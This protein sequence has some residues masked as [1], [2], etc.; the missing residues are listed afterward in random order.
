V[1]PLARLQTEFGFFIN[2]EVLLQNAEAFFGNAELLF[3]NAEALMERVSLG[4]KSPV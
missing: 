1:N 3:V 2:A 4:T